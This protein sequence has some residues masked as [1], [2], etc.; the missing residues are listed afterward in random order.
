MIILPR[1]FKSS[2]LFGRAG[3]RQKEREN[4]NTVSTL[5][6]MSDHRWVSV[7]FVLF[8]HF[9]LD[10]KFLKEKSWKKEVKR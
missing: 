10:V 6:I 5:I 3:R 8:Q 9:S 7:F 1:L 4:T 2:S